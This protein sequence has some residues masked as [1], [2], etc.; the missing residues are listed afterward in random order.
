[1]ALQ[2]SG[3]I[4]LS[5]IAAEFG[6]SVPHALSEYYGVES[7]DAPA[8]GQIKFSNFYGGELFNAQW[9]GNSIYF[10]DWGLY[11]SGSSFYFRA[12]GSSGTTLYA[13]T[14]GTFT[15]GSSIGASTNDLNGIK[16]NG[17]NTLNPYHNSVLYSAYAVSFTISSGFTGS[18]LVDVNSNGIYYGFETSGGNMRTRNGNNTG[19]YIGLS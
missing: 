12:N 17:D 1:M 2:S 6:G 9:S 4:K 15:D 14:S 19:A 7:S 13:S 11:T 18:A 3:Q 8:S 10:S 16:G 5:E